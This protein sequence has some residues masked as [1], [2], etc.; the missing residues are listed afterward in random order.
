MKTAHLIP[1]ATLY[2]LATLAIGVSIGFG[3]GWFTRPETIIV[4]QGTANTPAA[5]SS[6][7]LMVVFDS[8]K[9]RTWNTVDW[10]ET[11]TPLEL[12]QK[13]AGN[14]RMTLTTGKDAQGGTTVDSLEAD[15]NTELAFWNYYVNNAHPPRPPDKYSLRPGDVVVWV[16]ER[17][18]TK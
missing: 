15:A 11:M 18:A 3:A 8:A 7:Q 14:E 4:K 17:I 2:N 6:V 12:L 13:V 1:H 9:V 16:Y 10:H 5:L